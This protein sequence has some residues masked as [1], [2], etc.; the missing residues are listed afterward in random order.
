MNT[1][2]T[3]VLHIL[4][5]VPK[6]TASSGHFAF[7]YGT[8]D[9]CLEDPLY[10]YHL[11]EYDFN[12]QTKGITMG[13]C[14]PKQCSTRLVTTVLREAFKVSGL[15]IEVYRVITDPDTY[16]FDYNWVFYVTT[17]ILLLLT[18]LVAVA[19]FRKERTGWTKGFAIQDN[20]ARMLT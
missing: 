16:P 15:P 5:H 6:I 11:I 3:C 14:L 1:I 20:L 4:S 10:R 7:Q 19:S 2:S 13:L 17:L 18:L 12:H 8:Y 9:A